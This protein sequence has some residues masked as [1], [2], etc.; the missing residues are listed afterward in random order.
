MYQYLIKLND[1]FSTP[2]M[3]MAAKWNSLLAGMDR[4]Q[5]R[6]VGGFQRNWQRVGDLFKKT[7]GTVDELKKKIDDLYKKRGTLDIGLDR[8]AI[9]ATNREIDQLERKLA[10]VEGRKG[11]GFGRSV[12]GGLSAMGGGMSG[13]LLAG[14]IYGA[15]AYGVLQA[16]QAAAQATIAPAMQ[17][18]AT[19]FQLNELTNNPAFVSQLEK[20]FAGY[21]PQKMGELF[22]AS[23]KLIGAGVGQNELFGTVKMLNNLSAL[24]NTKVDELAMIQAKVR[25]TGY[26]QGDEMD[27]FRERGINLNPYIAK[28]LGV[29]E[30][31]VKKLQEKGLITY[32]K[33][34]KALEL[35][36]GPNSR[37]ANVA[38]RKR[39]STSQGRYEYLT[40]QMNER[41]TALGLKTLPMV[42]RALEYAL[43]W[44][45]RVSALEGPLYKLGVAFEPLLIGTGKLL[46]AFGVLDSKF[47]IS[48]GFVEKF[49]LM[50]EGIGVVVKGLG[51]IWDKIQPIV[52]FMYKISPMNLVDGLWNNAKKAIWQNVDSKQYGGVLARKSEGMNTV[53]RRA[54]RNAR[55]GDGGLG[56]ADL[57]TTTTNAF[58]GKSLAQAA[59]I[60]A[61]VEGAAKKYVTVNV[62]SLIQ[63]SEI[64]VAQINEGV[65]DL[66]GKMIDALLRVINSA[67]AMS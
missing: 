43:G 58:G 2:A 64:H 30:N 46:Q 49:A 28:V 62:Q 63:K 37:F 32:E 20:Q 41:L 50:I 18:E 4:V 29:Q 1:M 11:G 55:L 42:N 53:A 31:Q 65:A 5:Q 14:G 40:G 22:G 54:N 47:Q 25:A 67:T 36:V 45:D 21:A 56:G 52:G 66:E 61:A 13:M 39:D 6:V 34:A 23:Q 35:F 3:Q 24:S 10:R 60:N 16:G 8:S 17:R 59:G 19:R 9:N 48:S 44:F 15:A 7:G 12:A 27:M 26:V 38:E 33:F 57:A 51:L